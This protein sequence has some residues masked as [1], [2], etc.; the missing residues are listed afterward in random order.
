MADVYGEPTKFWLFDRFQCGSVSQ[1]S[2]QCCT[3]PWIMKATDSI[4][5]FIHYWRTTDLEAEIPLLTGPSTF[6]WVKSP[7]TSPS[8]TENTCSCLCLSID[9]PPCANT[10][11]LSEQCTSSLYIVYAQ[12]YK[13]VCVLR[14]CL[15][16]IE[17]VRAHWIGV[18]MFI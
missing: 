10:G 9:Y 5:G 14:F 3:P 8:D 13:D 12:P 7:V 6:R 17:G 11:R 1:P 18:W 4:S 16:C 2:V 15:D